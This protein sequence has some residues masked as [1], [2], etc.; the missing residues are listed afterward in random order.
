M[1]NLT[2]KMITVITEIA[3]T[4]AEIWDVFDICDKHELNLAE[5]SLIIALYEE[6]KHE[7]LKVF[8]QQKAEHHELIA[9]EITEHFVSTL[10]NEKTKG[11]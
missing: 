7:M 5:E 3:E 8:E 10:I 9:C 4:N 11:F 1:T 6:S 2:E